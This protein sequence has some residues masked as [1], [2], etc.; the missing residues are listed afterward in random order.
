MCL[1]PHEG[2]LREGPY[3][4]LYETIFQVTSCF[5]KVEEFENFCETYAESTLY[6]TLC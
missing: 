4:Q 5:S 3:T 6:S 2:P 1:K